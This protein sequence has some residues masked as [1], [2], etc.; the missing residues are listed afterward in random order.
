MTATLNSNG[1]VFGDGSA[2]NTAARA[3]GTTVTL[4]SAAP[5]AT[6]TS[7][8]NQSI[9]I[10]NDST[11][12][13]NP[14][15]TLPAMNASPMAAGSG[16]FIFNNTTPYNVA[17]KDSGGVIREYIAPGAEYTLNIT[18]VS[19]ATGRWFTDFPPV[20][21][22]YDDTT[23]TVV[24]TAFKVSAANSVP[25]YLVVRLD[26]SSFALVWTEQGD[27]QTAVS[28]YARLY[29]V[30]TTTKAITAGNLITVVSGWQFT[31][32]GNTVSDMAYDSD[33]AG[34]A[35][36]AVTM[37]NAA[38]GIGAAGIRYFGLSASG[39]VLY[40][41]A[42]SSFDTPTGACAGSG[43][44]PVTY[45]GY[46]G[47]G[48]AY[49]LSFVI[50]SSNTTQN[51]HIRGCTVTGTTAPVLTNSANNTSIALTLTTP[52]FYGARTGLTTFVC[53]AN[54]N[55]GRAV[56]YTPASNTF[57]ITTRTNQARL[58]IEQGST[59]GLSS[60]SMG[61]FM[62]SS[63]KAFFGANVYDIANAG[64]AGVTATLSTGFTFK[65]NQSAA[66]TTTNSGY[67][68]DPNGAV[69]SAIYVSGTS[70]IAV[71]ENARWQCD[72]SQATLNLQ[73]TGQETTVDGDATL[74]DT[75]FPLLAKV[76]NTAAAL[77]GTLVAN[78]GN[79]ATPIT[80]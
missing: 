63:G 27:S 32:Y 44:S 64:A 20:A 19:S 47:S 53:G 41:T 51:L 72:P 38:N 24:T 12:A 61:G 18:D 13:I 75:G 56:S 31:T 40:A 54:G 35:L 70:V 55:V 80:I 36:V 68:I 62:Y 59:A 7:A 29:T 49:A 78:V 52:T 10:L 57:T 26:T 17:L 45:I 15:V 23:G 50:N 8:S 43:T 48:G 16:Y 14:S 76:Y 30:N 5:N 77:G 46:L 71:S 6:L 11:K 3:G 65:Y 21:V 9:L 33:G 58:D 66:Y 1:V 25:K 42:V 79:V 69:R 60:F 34:H 4:T 28:V 73:R 39:G 22:S 74:M 67:N 2:Q 37:Y